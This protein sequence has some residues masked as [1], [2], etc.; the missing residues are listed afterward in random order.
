[1]E[2]EINALEALRLM[3]DEIAESQKEIEKDL[4]QD[5]ERHMFVISDVRL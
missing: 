3:D 1:M 5:L 4:R 2:E